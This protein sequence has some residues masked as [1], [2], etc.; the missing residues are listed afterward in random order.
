MKVV[1]ICFDELFP[2]SQNVSSYK[3]NRKGLLDL[4]ESLI[5]NC[6][7][8]TLILIDDNNYYQ[9]MRY[10]LIQ[11]CRKFAVSF[12]IVYF[13]LSVEECLTR[14]HQRESG[15]LPENVIKKMC[16]A[17]EIPLRCFQ[18]SDA[19]QIEDFLHYS[20]ERFSNPL[21]HAHTV[22]ERMPMA[23]SQ[24]HVFDLHLRKLVSGKLKD[25]F[26]D[27][28][29][30]AEKLNNRKKDILEGIR[31]CKIAVESLEDLDFIFES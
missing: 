16:S 20:E 7:E 25:T 8:K 23:Q 17:L 29:L 26:E 24:I 13:P 18:F 12:G 28:K 27:K 2:W 19:T 14:N 30:L 11:L 15:R 4:V 21:K 22:E 31:N 9:S 10:K 1:H 5:A 3:E 6:Q